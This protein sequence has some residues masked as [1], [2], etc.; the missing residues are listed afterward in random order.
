MARFLL[1]FSSVFSI[2]LLIGL[3]KAFASCSCIA[4]PYSKQYIY[5]TQTWYGTKRKWTCAYTC[6]DFQQKQTQIIGTSQDWYM[7]D[8][9]LEGICDGL[10]Y[11]NRYS[12]FKNDFIWS[13]EEAR[14]FDPANSTAP[15]LQAW[16]KANCR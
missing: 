4:D 11:V 10:H 8:K 2:S 6:Q 14:Y 7:S 12:S 3:P 13:F 1:L 15:E 16:S 9:G 5:Y